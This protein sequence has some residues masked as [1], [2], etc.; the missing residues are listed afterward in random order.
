[1]TSDRISDNAR[2]RFLFLGS[3]LVLL[4]TLLVGLAREQRWGQPTV[5]LRL[6]SRDASGLKPGQEVRISGMPVGLV[7]SLTLQPDASVAIRLQ[8]ARRYAALIGP[9]SVASQGQEGFVGDRFV[10]ISAD[11]Q[12]GR[13][14]T[15]LND[16]SLRYHPPIAIA[17]LLQQLAHTQQELE[18]TLRN[19][20]RLTGTD[21]PQT[22][23]EAR[24]SLSSVNALAAT[25]QRE[26]RDTAP[27]L[28]QTLRQLTRTGSSTE[29]T[30]AQAQ[31]LLRASQPLL[32]RTLQDIQQLSQSSRRLLQN[33]L[34]IAGMEEPPTHPK[35]R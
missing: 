21:L 2:D 25:L 1:M 18:A 13:A 14:H 19:T 27:E 29:Q 32:I 34:G 10:V 16:H 6:S 33:L 17:T 28:R 22:L 23:R 30:S 31:Q 3:A 26:T 5:E 7:Q 9:R 4:A 15:S 12:P 8:I 24:R 11:P 35:S 20:H